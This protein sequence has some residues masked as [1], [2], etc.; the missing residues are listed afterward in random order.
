MIYVFFIIFFTFMESPD[1]CVNTA[2]FKELSAHIFLDLSAHI[3]QGYACQS[4]CCPLV[5]RRCVEGAV[6]V[7]AWLVP[8]EARPL[9]S[10]ASSLKGE[11]G[12]LSEQSLAIALIPVLRQDEQVLEIYPG[13]AEEC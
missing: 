11:L 10:A 5:H 9:Q 4:E 3:L 13:A 2:I 6:K 7:Y 12:Q 1:I 8:V